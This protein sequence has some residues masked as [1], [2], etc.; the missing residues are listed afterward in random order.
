MR[1]VKP[2]KPYKDFPLTAHPNGTWCKKIKGKLYHFGG[3]ADP[4]SALAKYR[5][6]VDDIQA[7]REP[8]PMEEEGQINLKDLSF[9][10]LD[11]KEKLVAIK[12]LSQRMLFDYVRSCERICDIL[13][14]TRIVEGLR[15]KDFD[16]LYFQL[17]KDQAGK[18]VSAVT[19]AN[20]IRMAKVLFKFASDQSHIDAPLK[21]GQLFK[22]PGKDELRQART[23]AGKKLFEAG[24]LRDMLALLDGETITLSKVDEET[25]KPVEVKGK[26]NP[27]FRAMVLLGINC[28]FGQS[29][30]SSLPLSAI[31]LDQSWIEF[32]RP[33]THV[34]RKCPLWPETVK[35]LREAVSIRPKP[36]DDQFSGLAFLTTH[37]Q[38]YV[39]VG[40]EG[41]ALDAIAGEFDKIRA[42]LEI[43][44]RR[45][46]FYSLRRTFETVA[47][48]TRDQV[49]ID[50]VMGHAAAS[51][52][53]GAVYRQSV[54]D[55]RLKAVANHV[56]AWL[57]PEVARAKKPENATT[58]TD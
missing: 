29:D 47:G 12:K 38:P 23:V 39:R 1:A 48:D 41:A 20:R 15:P 14:K 50:L 26:R 24:E 11:T 13:G 17:A 32:P 8:S 52:D 25:G 55:E 34:E 18:P 54:D 19:L 51:N 30:C 10:F 16:N 42:K 2:E 22:I 3:W 36:R 40:V 43:K 5:H 56:R 44:G 53:M 46:A 35:A 9:D 6:D 37:G 33:K 28:G 57:W 45:T 27:V 49:A 7:G 58:A 21:F 4:D 31:N